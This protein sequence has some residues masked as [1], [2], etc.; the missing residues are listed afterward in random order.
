MSKVKVKIEEILIQI[1]LEIAR[2]GEGAL[3]IITDSSK[4]QRLGMPRMKPFSVYSTGA[5]KLL[6]S[7]GIIDGAVIVTTKGIVKAYDV[8]VKVNK[9]Y[10]GYG[11]R[12]SAAIS[13]SLDKDTSSVILVSEEERKVKIF[14]HGKLVMQLDA[15]EKK[16]DTHVSEAVNIIE[17]I[18]IGTISTIGVS[19]LAPTVG[20]TLIPGI[21]IF[22]GSY[23]VIKALVE[24][25]RKLKVKS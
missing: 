16:V 15:L 24:S 14:K 8:M 22:G 13:A 20:I 25:L 3:F 7:L 23:A 10:N 19:V 21:I 17:S 11:T 1:G 5:R 4:Y 12:H 18:G 6:F 9:V 2:K